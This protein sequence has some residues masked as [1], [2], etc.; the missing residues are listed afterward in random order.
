MNNI[1]KPK[2]AGFICEVAFG[3]KGALT[4]AANITTS[5]TA[6]EI[7]DYLLLADRGRMLTDEEK[8]KQLIKS[9]D[10]SVKECWRFQKELRAI[11]KRTK[12][13]D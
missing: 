1:D 7:G 8:I 3:V 13:E 11:I 12:K 9:L 4:Q 6:K 2:D 10:Q 5:M